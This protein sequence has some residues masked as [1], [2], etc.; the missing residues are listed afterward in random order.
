MYESL[1]QRMVHSVPLYFLVKAKN[2]MGLTSSTSCQLS[3]Y[4][5]TLPQGRVM[6][7]FSS[8]SHT[9]MLRG[10]TLA[11]DDSVITAQ[12]VCSSVGK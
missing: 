6:F 1:F 9:G 11:L 3:T 5:M 4:D 7:D 10:S 8:T 2:S 12:R